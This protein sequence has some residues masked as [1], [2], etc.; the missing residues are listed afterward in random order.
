MVELPK[1]GFNSSSLLEIGDGEVGLREII[2]DP[3]HDCFAKFVV[4]AVLVLIVCGK[5]D[6]IVFVRLADPENTIFINSDVFVQVRET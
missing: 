5:D 2:S 1:T 4:K 3:E 6:E